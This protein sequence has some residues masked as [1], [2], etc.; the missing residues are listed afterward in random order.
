MFLVPVGVIGYRVWRKHQD[1][2]QLKAAGGV[3]DETNAIE[4]TLDNSNDATGNQQDGV[5][6][7][8][9][10]IDTQVEHD[11]DD[12]WAVLTSPAS[13]CSGGDDHVLA[14]Q[15]GE[16]L[17]ATNHE[18]RP[19]AIAPRHDD[20]AV[21]EMSLDALATDGLWK[22]LSKFWRD[23]QDMRRQMGNAS[24]EVNQV[25]TLDAPGKRRQCI[26]PP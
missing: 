6:Q 23:T 19:Q 15:E 10:A 22:G 7:A 13:C 24:D 12:G 20:D 14:V 1:E 5:D 8:F 11:D 16:T 26:P 17:T 25:Q 2:Q 21:V 4:T 3:V 18:T 9:P